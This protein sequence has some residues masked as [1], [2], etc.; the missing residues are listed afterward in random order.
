MI[1]VCKMFNLTCLKAIWTH[2]ASQ[3][4]ASHNSILILYSMASVLE[5]GFSVGK[6]E[7]TSCFHGLRYLQY[8]N[9]FLS[10]LVKPSIFKS[11]HFHRRTTVTFDVSIDN[12]NHVEL[13]FVFLIFLGENLY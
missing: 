5:L 4:W 1:L 11:T 8:L 9:Y 10:V 3:N 7:T 13:T 12:D 6:T 2:I